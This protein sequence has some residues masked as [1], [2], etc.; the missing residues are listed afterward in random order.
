MKKRIQGTSIWFKLS[1]QRI[2]AGAGYRVNLIKRKKPRFGGLFS[3]STASAVVVS[4]PVVK[5]LSEPL[6]GCTLLK[7]KCS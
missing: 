1:R 7:L 4:L 3:K 5:G 2:S 6:R